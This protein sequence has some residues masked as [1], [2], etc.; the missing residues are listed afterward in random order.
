MIVKKMPILQGFSDFETVKKLSKYCISLSRFSPVFYDI[1]TTGLS[2]YSTFTY[3]IGCVVYEDGMWILYQLFGENEADEENVLH[4]FFDIA[5]NKTCT[6]QYNGDRFDQPYLETRAKILDIPCP[7][8]EIPSLDL[9]Q[10]LK[11]CKGLLKLPRMKQTDL[12]AFLRMPPRLFCDGKE[13][14][15]LY[16]KYMK[17]HENN[18]LQELLG[19]NQEDLTGL[20]QVMNM[21][22]YLLLF[23]GAYEPLSAEITE[24]L[25]NISLSLPVPVPALFSN[26]NQNF[27]IS[28]ESEKAG[29]LIPL[30]DGKLRQYY[31][32]YKNYDYLPDEDTAIPKSLSAYMDKSLRIPAKKETCYTWFP[33]NE[34]FLTD[35]DRQMKYLRNTLPFLLSTL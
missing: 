14:I 16:R 11:P 23:Q 7:L 8:G 1:E 21:A 4:A 29:L 22:A 35:P 28:G 17:Y 25:L 18:I 13:G 33:C 3:L 26:G 20:G 5:K 2:Q 31:A 6:I 9:Y 12:E 19:H 30:K 15:R 32:D 24:D 27:Y 34:M 10:T